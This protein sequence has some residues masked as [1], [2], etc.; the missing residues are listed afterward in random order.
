MVIIKCKKAHY[1][2]H[3]NKELYMSSNEERVILTILPKEKAKA[4]GSPNW[5]EFT[6]QT[7]MPWGPWTLQLEPKQ[8][9]VFE[10]I[11][12]LECSAKE[13]VED[14]NGVAAES[15]L[16]HDPT[17][18][19]FLVG[20]SADGTVRWWH[21][22]GD[23]PWDFENKK[24]HESSIRVDG[25]HVYIKGYGFNIDPHT[26]ITIDILTGENAEH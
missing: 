25:G 9:V 13:Y 11:T 17:A 18:R 15:S 5:G 12:V 19:H 23:T 22:L 16:S 6:Y 4:M 2:P 3:L 10:G 21:H 24:F 8:L 20:R 14:E 1:H 7:K 26:E